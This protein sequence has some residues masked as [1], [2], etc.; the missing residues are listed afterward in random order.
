MKLL[1]PLFLVP[2]TLAQNQ[3]PQAQT[4]KPAEPM[5]LPQA[6]VLPRPE[7][8]V[9]ID[10]TLT[11][12]P[13]LPAI[14]LSDQRQLSGTADNAWRGP[15]DCSALMFTMWDERNLYVAL[16][17]RD[18]W[19]HPLEAG[20]VALNEIPV[21]DSVEITFDPARDTRGGG[22]DPGRRDDRTFWLADENSRSVVLWDQLGGKA[23]LLDQPDGRCVVL[24]DKEQSV[25]TYEAS[26]PWQEILPPGTTPSAGLVIDMQV[27]VNDFDE[28]TDAMPQTRIGWTFGCSPIV[29]P[30]LLGS[31]MLVDNRDALQGK[32]PAFPPKPAV[33]PDPAI[34]ESRWQELTA[35]LLQAPPRVCK[36]DVLPADV[37]GAARLKVLEEIDAEVAR[38]PR[39]DYVQLLQRIHRRMNREVAGM[40]ARGLP[41]WWRER[42]RSVSKQAEDP[43]PAGS[44]RLFRLP[45]GGW[46]VRSARNFMIDPVG[47]GIAELLWGGAEFCILT[48]PLDIARRNDQLLVRMLM[49][50]PPHPVLMHIAVHLPLVNMGQVPLVQPGESY[51]S[52]LG[53]FVRALAKPREDGSVTF[54]CSY[55]VDL[56]EAPS[57]LIVG[58]NLQPDEVPEQPVDV[59][60]LSPRNPDALEIAAKANP[61][62][63]VIDDSFLCQSVPGI[64][65]MALTNLHLL[66]KALLPRPS[67]LLA[68]GESWDVARKP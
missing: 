26:L 29:D 44:L 21:A 66:Q 43:V 57:L 31:I 55:R 4:Q 3:P 30:G 12:W 47:D 28:S 19:H 14:V 61:G 60:L 16:A 41:A 11:D 24:H 67:V 13:E 23:R 1:A 25:T 52:E 53:A 5:L 42:L 15:R 49:A 6:V 54:S 56:P 37:G 7:T 38:Y 68:P 50:K 34:A 10:G 62:L 18:E 9:Q 33:P 65:R 45:M 39:V 17:V 46:L 59:M 51:G 40:S 8:P 58:Q 2:V 63:I 27:V 64:P 22:L 32:V 35:K 48:E 36:G 20:S